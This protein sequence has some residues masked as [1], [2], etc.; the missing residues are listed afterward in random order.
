MTKFNVGVWNEWDRLTE[1]I[2]GDMTHDVLPFWSPDWGRYEG[3]K[4]Y[5]EIGGG[6]TH[7]SAFPERT[8]ATITQ[9][10]Q[11]ADLLQ[12]HGILVHR[13]PRLLTSEEKQLPPIGHW[14]QYPRD[15]HIVIGKN[16]I[17]TNTRV[18]ARNKEHLVWSSIWEEKALN[19][20]EVKYVRMPGVSPFL[21]ELNNE[22]FLQDPRLFL[23]GGDTFILGDDILV[24]CSSLA[25]S[26]SGIRWLQNFLGDRW[27]IYTVKIKPKWIHLDC[28]FS[29]IREGLALICLEALDQN[30]PHPI[31]DWKII[32][33]SVNESHSMGTNTLC[34]EPGVVLIGDEHKRLITEIEKNNATA[35][36]ISFDQAS[37]WGGGIRCSTHPVNRQS[38]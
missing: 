7:L 20:L 16:I 8:K 28:I 19:D 10:N 34:I 27:R 35:I 36:P 31:K 22:D 25:S 15:P 30:L 21:S 33:V 32:E 38:L 3:C 9:T 1:V 11:L 17:E 24:G 2:V 37:E 14:L 6:K 29:V 23:E 4:E 26:P 18:T 5:S 13:P 12:S